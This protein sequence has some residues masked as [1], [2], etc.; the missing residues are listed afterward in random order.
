MCF[1]GF[2]RSLHVAYLLS[3]F[4]MPT[5]QIQEIDAKSINT[6]QNAAQEGQCEEEHDT[7]R[8]HHTRV[9]I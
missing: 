2:P 5:N 7:L 3:R 9:Y 8:H 1:D 6:T 4:Q